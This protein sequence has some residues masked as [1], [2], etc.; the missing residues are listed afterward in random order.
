MTDQKKKIAVKF[1]DFWDNF[2]PEKSLFWRILTERYEIE[3][4]DTPDYLFFSVFGDS[5]LQYD[6]IKIFY[7]GEN[8]V[9]DFNLADY[10]I[11]FEYL[12]FGDRYMRLPN[13]YL[14]ETDFR[15]MEGKTSFRHE[16]LESKA[17]FCSFVYSNGN[18][19][20]ERW[21]MFDLLNSYKPVSSGGRYRNNIGGPV[22]D[23]REFQQKHKFS[24][25]F[26]NCSHSGYSTEKLIQSFA[27]QTIPIYW[28]DPTIG[29][30]FNRGAFIDASEYSSFDDIVTKIK[31][32]DSDEN[33]YL[34]MMQTPALLKPEVDGFDAKL[35]ELSKFLYHI[36]DQEITSAQR[37]SRT[38][39]GKRYLRKQRC[40]IKAY[41][42]S[43]S[44]ILETTYRNYFR[45]HF[46]KGIFSWRLDMILKRLLSNN[47]PG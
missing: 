15:A 24:I 43:F 2:V 9:P 39:W 28:G 25:A 6:C 7:T 12:S 37:F 19:S 1:V 31:A 41:R 29:Q 47:K 13:Y 8:Q 44:G 46:R 36:F 40:M 3:P 16:D 30:T 20:P 17:G 14:Y 23:K 11:G 26:E 5:H 22:K 32:I 42:H 34:Q 38:Y 21:D 4:S 27:A 45:K 35:E 10:A 18:S 33:L